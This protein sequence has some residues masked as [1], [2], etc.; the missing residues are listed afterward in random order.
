VPAAVA[1]ATEM[2]AGSRCCA[3]RSPAIAPRF[4]TFTGRFIAAVFIDFC[5]KL[6]TDTAGPVYLIVDGHPVHYWQ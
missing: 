5:H 2:W 4:S 6:L 1:P 3:A